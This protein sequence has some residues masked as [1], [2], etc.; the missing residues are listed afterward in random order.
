MDTKASISKTSIQA[1]SKECIKQT[2][3][4]T[5]AQNLAHDV[6]D[7]ITNL[8][9]DA[10]KYARRTR[11]SVIRL[12]HLLFAT[13]A[14]NLCLDILQL[15]YDWPDTEEEGE[16]E[17]GKKVAVQKIRQTLDQSPPRAESP[18]ES[19]LERPINVTSQWKKSERVQLMANKKFPLSK[20]QQRFYLL[21]TESCMGSSEALRRNALHR[22]S[23]DSSLQQM[24]PKLSL[25]IAESVKV[26]VAQHNFAIL[27]Y[28]M[29][30]VQGLLGNPNLRLENFVSLHIPFD[31]NYLWGRPN[32]FLL[33]IIMYLPYVSIYV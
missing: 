3:T 11:C 33:L 14:N 2:L 7:D 8:I 30:M 10:F 32:T 20:E 13:Q 16:N 24:L 28:L 17:S 12:E 25:F 18:E 27:L 21:I 23:T 1:I 31:F 15:E 5:I 9:R 4:D 22:I 6:R 26:N 19:K 29:R